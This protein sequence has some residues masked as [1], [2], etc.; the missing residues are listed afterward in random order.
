MS[1]KL[2]IKSCKLRVYYEKKSIGKDRIT[3]EAG[4]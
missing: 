4:K 2:R 3:S 1:Y